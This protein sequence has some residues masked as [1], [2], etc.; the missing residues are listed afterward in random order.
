MEARRRKYGLNQPLAHRRRPLWLEFLA[1]FLNPLVLIL[2]FASGLS[3]ATGNVTSFVIVIV[4]VVL[5][6]TLDFVQEMRARERRGSVAP[7][8]RR[9][10]KVRRDGVEVSEPVD[11]LVPGTWSVWPPVIWC[12][13]TAASSRRATC[14]STRPC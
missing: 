9:A 4:M 13:P 3:A 12:R 6:V 8:R 1:R 2:L 7:H 5:S 14:S 10:R 11:Q